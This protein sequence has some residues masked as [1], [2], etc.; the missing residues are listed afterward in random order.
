[1]TQEEIFKLIEKISPQAKEYVM[2]SAESTEVLYSLSAAENKGV[3]LKTDNADCRIFFASFLNEDN[4]DD[5]LELIRL[6][7]GKSIFENSPKELCF[8]VYG[9]DRKIINSVRELGFISDMEG[10]HLEYAGKEPPRTKSPE[11]T[12]KGF[13]SDMIDGSADLFDSAYYR[14]NTDNGRETNGYT[15]HKEQ[16]RQRLIALNSR[17]RFFSFWLNG[18]LAGAYIFQQDYITDLVVRPEFQNRGYGSY[19]LAHCIENMRAKG[20]VNSIRLRVAG[21][22][23]G[24]KR[25]YERNGFVEIACFAEHTYPHAQAEDL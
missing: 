21:S 15:A 25:F 16:F 2:N 14:L 9:N 23:S 20:A 1:M 3:F 5:V 8:N 13:E 7:A 19:M 4:I 22:N 24:A 6:K 18:D 11:L 10:Y 12:V 17:G